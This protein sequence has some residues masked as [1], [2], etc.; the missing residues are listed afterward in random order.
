[1]LNQFMNKKQNERWDLIVGN[2]LRHMEE[3]L[4][5]SSLGKEQEALAKQMLLFEQQGNTETQEYKDLKQ[6]HLE[7]SQKLEQIYAEFTSS[8]PAKFAPI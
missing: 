1:M 6:K 8:L 7:V 3:N 4:K 5:N 2:N